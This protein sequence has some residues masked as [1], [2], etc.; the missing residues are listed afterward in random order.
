VLVPAIARALVFLATPA[1]HQTK[2]QEVEEFCQDDE[3]KRSHVVDG[4]L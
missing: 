1:L 3:V 4:I 2:D